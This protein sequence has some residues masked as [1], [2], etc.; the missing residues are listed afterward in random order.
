VKTLQI[1]NGDLVIGSGG[2]ATVTG[3]AK[4]RQDLSVA[5]REPYG[6]DRFHPRWGSMLSGF[7]GGVLDKY[8]ASA[9]SGEVN[10][11]IGNY[12]AV[13]HDQMTV[14]ASQGMKVRYSTGEVVSAVTKIDTRQSFDRLYVRAS[15]TTMSG[16]QIDIMTT[17][18]V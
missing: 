4:L 14:A 2:Y 7:V 1:K 11:I 10:R 13:Q 17:A 5:V 16:E 8:A 18:E 15:L 12:V 9:V 6:C 3:S